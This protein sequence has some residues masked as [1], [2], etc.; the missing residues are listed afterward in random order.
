M[1]GFIQRGRK[2]KSNG[3]LTAGS[4]EGKGENEQDSLQEPGGNGSN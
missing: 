4:R 3:G 2:G 1:V